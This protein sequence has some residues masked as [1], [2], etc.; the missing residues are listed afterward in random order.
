MIAGSMTGLAITW[1]RWL[2]G[3]RKIV[4]TVI[5]VVID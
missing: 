3:T 5:L 4:G 1:R 2:Y